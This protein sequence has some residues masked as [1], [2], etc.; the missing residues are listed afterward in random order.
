MKNLQ[1]K[2]LWHLNPAGVLKRLDPQLQML[3]WR[4]VERLLED[5]SI[6]V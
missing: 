1:G 4:V 2:H 6:G 3:A 5:F